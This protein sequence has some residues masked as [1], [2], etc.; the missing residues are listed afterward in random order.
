MR[1]VIYTGIVMLSVLCIAVVADAAPV[2]NLPSKEAK[3]LRIDLYKQPDEQSPIV[4][5][6]DPNE[7]IVIILTKGDWT[8]V[9]DSK[10]G[11]VG[12]VKNKTLDRHGMFFVKTITQTF[13]NPAVIDYHVVQQVD[14][15][16]L[17][18]AQVERLRDYMGAWQKANEHAINDLIQE[19]ARALLNLA[20]QFQAADTMGPHTPVLQPIII[21][22]D[23]KMLKALGATPQANPPKQ[24]QTPHESKE[25]PALLDKAKFGWESFTKHFT[26]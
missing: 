15:S 6:V 7:P 11:D 4:T 17:G 18:K 22:P 1:N 23:A 9:A 26:E 2:A 13:K 3:S 20:Q 8:K 10:N 21:V 12:W 16:P 5:S 25:K 24:A 19:N 14:S